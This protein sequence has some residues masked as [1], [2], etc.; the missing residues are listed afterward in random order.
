[1]LTDD[2]LKKIDPKEN[3]KNRAGWDECFLAMAFVI[4]RKSF[5]PSSKCG[6]IIVSKDKRILSGGYNGPI[7]G[8]VDE[9]V[10]LIRPDRYKFMIHGEENSLLAYSGSHQ[11]IQG[12]TVYVTGRP[13][14][15]CLRMMIQKGVTK[16]VYGR[17]DTNIVDREDMDAQLLMLKHHP[18]VEIKEMQNYGVEKVLKETMDYIE[19]K[20]R[21]N[22]NY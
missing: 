15:R 4:A 6:A 9:E 22:P 5:D 10:P 21:V 13:C 16:I 14:S 20:N 18:E 19:E 1:M 3:L 7:K 12:S 2:E 17:N 11:D 8:S